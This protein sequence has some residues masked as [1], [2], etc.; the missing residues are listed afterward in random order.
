M[1]VTVPRGARM[2]ARTVAADRLRISLPVAVGATAAAIGAAMAHQP[3]A[4]LALVAALGLAVAILAWPETA[5]LLVL[6]LTY[7]S[8]AAVAVKYHGAP[9]VLG[10]LIPLLL[11][12]PVAYH[13]LRGEPL[14]FTTGFLLVLGFLGVE[15][16]STIFSVDLTTGWDQVRTFAFEGV[17][18]YFLLVNAIRTPAT[19]R[20]AIWALLAAGA[21]LSTLALLQRASGSYSIPYGGFA[22]VGRDYF[23]GRSSQPRVAGP[24]GDPNYYAQILL[25]LAPLGLMLTWAERSRLLRLLAFGAAALAMIGVALTASRGAG[26]AF[27]LLLVLMTVLRYIRV[28]ELAVIVAGL[29]ILL[30]ALPTYRDRVA[31]L[32]GVTNASTESSRHDTG[33]D[34]SVRSRK[35]EMLAA[36][37]V[38]IEHP[39]LGVGPDEFPLY[40]QEYARRLGG[41]VHETSKRGPREGEAANREAHNLFLGLAADLG[42]A[43]L[44]VFLA[45]LF[46]TARELGHARRYWLRRDPMLANIAT[47]FLLAIVGYLACGLFLTLAFER[48]FWLLLALAGATGAI[49]RRQAL[50]EKL[51]ERARPV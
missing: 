35:T 36:G 20:R 37:L 38:F 51:S 16:V 30:M 49:A 32:T 47:G 17:V 31:T 26:V 33:A 21:L 15:I 7:L 1:A 44:A 48:Y 46:L 2:S 39:V 4:V 19:L 43:G 27:L 40:Y 14:I 34:A 11:V 25:V 9:L 12:L 28:R 41:A 10:L 29:A 24:L 13:A 42:L 6:V 18:I 5:T 8:V 3:L 23:I 45:L 22:Q 50:A